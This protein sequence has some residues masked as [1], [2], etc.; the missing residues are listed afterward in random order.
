MLPPITAAE[1][2]FLGTLAAT[3]AAALLARRHSGRD[4]DGGLAEMKLNRWL[5]GLS[6]G[7]TANSGFIVTGAVGLG[8]AYGLQWVL[9]PISWLLGDL[10]FWYLF[11]A[12]INEL[13]RESRATTLSELLTDKLSN[14]T[15]SALA[16]LCAVV[17]LACLSGYTSAQ[18][19]AG[20]KF[21]SGAFALPEWTAL[22]LFAVVII[23]YSSIGGFRGSIYTDTLQAIIRVA[24]TI[25]AL[26]AVA[27]F[28]I[29][30]SSAFSRNIA[31]A[32][33]GFLNLFPGGLAVTVC[34]VL[35]FACAAI[36]FGL[37]QPQIVSRYLAGASPVETRSAWWIYV[38]FVQFT[39]IAMTVFGLML[40]GV[41]PDIADP[42]TG[43]SVFFQKNIGAI[44]TGIIVA[45]VFATIASTAN[46]LLVAMS[47]SITR[48]LLPRLF[49]KKPPIPLSLVTLFIGICTML[50][51]LVIHGSVFSIALSSVSLMGAGIAAA[52]MIKV[53]RW[54]HSAGSLL[55]TVVAGVISAV[56]WKLFQLS[57]LFNEAAVGM[58]VGL[59]INW[60]FVEYGRHFLSRAGHAH[61]DN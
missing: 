37:G 8:Y 54:R 43:L 47:Q 4:G 15:A 61:S 49:A 3:F 44:A 42:E 16:I 1:I 25:V 17:I 51:S 12:R 38:G 14:R 55:C 20:Q 24:G 36:G 35:G 56:L 31:S 19:L 34:F 50:L 23:A 5:V 26:V 6:A 53:L 30:D 13:G 27:W 41:M 32:G 60:L 29:E 28:A 9:L 18:W 58:G 11:P 46:G 39:W 10:V 48:D 2:V 21:L 52:V 22:G 45:D 40:R 57:S 33:D 7:T 59:L